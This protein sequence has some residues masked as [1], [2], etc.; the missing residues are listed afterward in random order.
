M[1]PSEE[2]VN[3]IYELRDAAEAK[4]RAE[5]ALEQAP[6]PQ[7]REAWL[8]AQLDLEQKT[9]AAIEVCHECGHEHA[10][11]APHGT[12]LRSSVIAGEGSAEQEDRL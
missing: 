10:A 3:A 2:K 12:P 7:R 6:T 9:F 11:G 1:A 4:A 5:K 8:D